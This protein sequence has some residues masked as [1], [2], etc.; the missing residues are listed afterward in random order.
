[1]ILSEQEMI[2]NGQ[3]FGLSSLGHDIID[4]E[5]SHRGVKEEGDS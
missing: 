1:M 5:C 2:L 3:T 4:N